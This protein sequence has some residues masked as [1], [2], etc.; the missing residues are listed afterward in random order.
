MNRDQDPWLELGLAT[1]SQV[2][3]DFSRFALFMKNS[4]V[5]VE[6]CL[7]IR[8]VFTSNDVRNWYAWIL[9]KTEIFEA[10][11]FRF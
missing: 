6:W 5:N 8:F 1:K 3:I 4:V 11:D 10:A 7:D 2:T 9:F